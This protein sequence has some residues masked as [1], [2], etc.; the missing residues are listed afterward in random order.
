MVRKKS[1]KSY[2]ALDIFSGCGG[3]TEGL[4]QAGFSVIGGL[5]I[6]HKASQTYRINHP[7]VELIEGDIRDIAIGDIQ[8]RWSLEKGELDLLAGCPPCQGFSTLRTKNGK[9]SRDIRNSL[10]EN[11]TQLVKGLS[12]KAVMLENV[13]GL[14]KHYRFK[15][16]I[17][18]LKKEGYKLVYGVLNVADYGVA[19]RRNRLIL[20]ACKK[21]EPAFAEKLG[22]RLTVADIIGDM[23]IITKDSDDIHAIPERRSNKVKNIIKAIPKNGGSRKDLPDHLVLKCHLQFSGFSD[24]YGRMRWEDQSPTITSGCH[25]PSKGRFLHP[26]ADRAITLREASMLQGFPRDYKFLKSHGK[27]SLGLMIGNALPPPFIKSHAR[28]IIKVLDHG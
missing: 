12:P 7:E 24:V 28:E 23:S 14:Q 5:E 6:D 27:E 2:I 13:P 3:L 11:F 9:T 21:S 16:F 4:K 15:S 10:I 18:T 20:L 26:E 17:S 19:Q 8:R 22:K 1:S 25:N